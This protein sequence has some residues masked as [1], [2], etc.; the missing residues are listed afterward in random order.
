MI[1]RLARLYGYFVRFQLSKA[2]QFRYDFFFRIIM[3]IGYY[4]VILGFFKA[5]FVHTAN[6]GPWNEDETIVFA[7]SFLVCDALFMTLVAEA[8]YQLGYLVNSGGF[9]YYLTRP[10][11]SFF[12][13]TLRNFSPN[14]LINFIITICILIWA[15]AQCDTPIT[16]MGFIGYC[17]LMVMGFFVYYL[18]RAI[19]A[20]AVFWTGSNE[21]AM[22]LFYSG[23]AFA[24]RPH[25]LLQGWPRRILMTVIPFVA[26]ASLPV[27]FLFDPTRVDIIWHMIGIIIYL[28]TLMV[29]VWRAGLNRYASASS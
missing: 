16:T 13:A 15:F 23:F 6:L 19:A 8:V 24:E 20:C 25:H 10:V 3:D 5:V 28:T 17:F 9:D 12:F 4:V 14:S 11:S 21:G 18:M 22:N 26:I 1:L 27:T 29:L 2:L 7:A